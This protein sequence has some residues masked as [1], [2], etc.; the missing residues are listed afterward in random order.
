MSLFTLKLDSHWSHHKWHFSFWSGRVCKNDQSMWIWQIRQFKPQRNKRMNCTESNSWH[1]ICTYHAS[2]NAHQWS[3][4][5]PHTPC[6][7]PLPLLPPQ[8]L[9]IMPKNLSYRPLE[10]ID[11]VKKNAP[12]SVMGSRS[13]KHLVVISWHKS[14]E[15]SINF[16]SLCRPTTIQALCFNALRS[17]SFPQ[18]DISIFPFTDKAIRAFVL[19]VQ[20][21]ADN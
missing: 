1:L 8:D 14:V 20:S 5:P 21:D 16:D 11:S 19:P 15:L 17:L 3:P 4:P 18:M 13:L 9:I 12:R 10:V 7:V 6:C 2:H